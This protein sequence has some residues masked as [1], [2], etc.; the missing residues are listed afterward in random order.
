MKMR[1]GTS[2]GFVDT[3]I[4]KK[5]DSTTV[6]ITRSLIPLPTWTVLNILHRGGFEA[7]LVGGCVRDL[8]LNRTPKDFDVVTNANLKQIK[9]LY[10]RA[11]I[12]GCKFP[13]CIVHVRGSV[14]EVSSFDTVAGNATQKK[15][16]NF[17]ERHRGCDEEDFVR[18]RDC[19][20]RDFTINSLL[21]DPFANIIYDYA[22]GMEDLKSLKLRTLAP[23]QLSFK[24]D[25]ARILRGLRIAARLG[26]TFSE[27]TE[28][29]ICS[30][31]P[32]IMSLS[33]SRIMMELNY[34]LSYGAAGPS[35]CLLQRFNLL[36]LLLPLQAAY[37]AQQPDKETAKCSTM[38]MVTA[39]Q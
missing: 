17:T 27:D 30:L 32:S 5:L 33:K 6:G 31:S 20:R 15:E 21:F 35:I 2:A 14:I 10:R 16:A 1:S 22:G 28:T 36:E 19:M 23:A 25:C 37:L 26:L 29:A 8:V 7:Y 9:K 3:S 13:I 4:W 24:E 18:W 34:M 39:E 12:V 38:F 11:F